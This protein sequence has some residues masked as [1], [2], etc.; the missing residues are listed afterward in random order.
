MLREAER[1][2][3]CGTRPAE[4]DPNRGGHPAAYTAGGRVCPGCFNV[5][6]AREKWQNQAGVHV[7]LNPRRGG[8]ADAR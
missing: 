3:G 2:P 4:W 1:C 6:T 8:A 5:E 7:V